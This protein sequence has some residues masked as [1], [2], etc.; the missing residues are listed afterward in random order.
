MIA[1]SQPS[2]SII[3]GVDGGGSRTRARLANARGETLGTGEAGASNP[4]GVG[5]SAATDQ[6]LQAIEGAFVDAHIP[7]QPIAAACLGMA[8]VGR[9]DE[10][11]EIERWAGAAITRHLEVTS[12]GG[13]VLAAGSEENW[14][15][16]LIAGTGSSAWGKT[17]DGRTARAGGWGYLIGD[18]G[19]AFHVAQQALHSAT[20]AADGR[21][22]ATRLLPAILE[23]W[24]LRDA[25]ELVPRVYRSGGKPS[26]LA[27]LAV[28]VQRAA[29]EDDLVARE[30]LLA[31]GDALASA[32]TAVA[33]ALQFEDEEIPLAL[34]GGFVLGAELVRARLLDALEA[35]GYCFTVGLVHEPVSGAV[36]L[37]HRVLARS[38]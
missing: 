26:E 25:T 2:A 30:L 1:E 5:M 10:R 29:E 20:Q 12:D 8:G 32:V 21:G 24:N 34:T 38:V 3:L 9:A 33:R 35:H 15:I 11:R 23:F 37:A 22:P 17:R 28:V 18:E 14:G 27:E 16:A 6:I 19:S 4:S 13:I 31:A 36:R 7:R